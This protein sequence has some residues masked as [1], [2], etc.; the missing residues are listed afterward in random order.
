MDVDLYLRLREKEG[1]FYPDELV[2]NLPAIQAGHPLADEWRIRARSAARL[3]RYL[4]RQSKPLHLLDLGCGNGWLTNFLSIP[5]RFVTGMDQNLPELHQAARVF[6]SNANLHFL[7]A[8]IFSAPFQPNTFNVI[9][10]A[11]VIQYFRDLPGLVKHLF[12]YLKPHGQIHIIDSP[13]YSID[14]IEAASL[15]SH[16]YYIG[17]GFPEMEKYYFHHALTSLQEFSVQL[18]YDPRA[19]LFRLQRLAGV[20]VSPFPWVM[21][22]K[23]E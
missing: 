8:D 16:E 23:D 22:A 10:L 5:D 6:S 19:N 13:L 11:S 14:E 9:I 18:L 2:A 12:N 7:Q 15:R 20:N 1:R 3:T 17:L 21:I 4:A